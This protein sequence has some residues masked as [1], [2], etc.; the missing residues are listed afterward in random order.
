M[1]SWRCVERHINQSFNLYGI[2]TIGPFI[3][4]TLHQISE[5]CWIRLWLRKLQ[6]F[7]DDILWFKKRV[8]WVELLSLILINGRHTYVWIFPPA[9]HGIGCRISCFH[10]FIGESESDSI[11]VSR[12]IETE[13]SL[14]LFLARIANSPLAV[15]TPEDIQWKKKLRSGVKFNWARLICTL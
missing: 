2:I 14:W 11:V 6:H 1:S 10:T 9:T 8:K 3:A 7:L 12:R 4:V 13:V 15:G 5:N